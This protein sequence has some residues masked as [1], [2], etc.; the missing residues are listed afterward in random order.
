[1]SAASETRIFGIKLGVDPKIAVG[2]LFGLA[3]LLYF[4]YGRGDQGSP[5]QSVPN[6]AVTT[7]VSSGNGTVPVSRQAKRRGRTT[8]AVLDRGTLRIR[9]VDAT[10]GDIDP[11]LRMDMLERL[12][13]VAAPQGGRSLFEIGEAAPTAAAIEKV[14]QVIHPAPVTPT[15]L[16]PAA[17][18]PVAPAVNIPLKFYGFVKTARKSDGSRGL[19]LDG[20]NVVVAAEGEVI[21]GHYR[22][23]T[24]SAQDARLEDTRLKQGQTLPVEPQAAQQ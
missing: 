11:T 17:A 16:P 18:V 7:Q 6:T 24:L 15:A 3:L 14:N 22:V 19:F 5:A 2:A 21:D 12:Q 13:T 20:D 1:M 10:R 9:P 8:M 4:L 23:V